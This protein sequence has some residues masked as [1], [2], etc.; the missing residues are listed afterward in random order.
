MD[1]KKLIIPFA[2]SSRWLSGMFSKPISTRVERSSS[3]VKSILSRNLTINNFQK[4][5]GTNE[6]SR[7]RL[8][9]CLTAFIDHQVSVCEINVARWQKN[10][11]KLE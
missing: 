10:K 7:F 5:N 2:N 6:K 11:K 4:Q 8:F 9:K 1:K 3:N